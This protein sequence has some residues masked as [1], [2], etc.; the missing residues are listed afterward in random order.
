MNQKLRFLCF[1]VI[2]MSLPSFWANLGYSQIKIDHSADSLLKLQIK[3]G[4]YLINVELTQLL[5]LSLTIA[6]IV[7]GGSYYYRRW[8]ILSVR[9][10]K[11]HAPKINIL[12]GNH[13]LESKYFLRHISKM[14][15]HSWAVLGSGLPVEFQCK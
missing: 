3:I 8:L 2:N 5:T 14:N 9:L 7:M 6:L 11:I 4:V 15:F 13:R 10:C 1:Q 12:D